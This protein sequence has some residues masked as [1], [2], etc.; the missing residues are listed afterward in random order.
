MTALTPVDVATAEQLPPAPLMEVTMALIPGLGL[1]IRTD[2]HEGD[3][4]LLEV[5]TGPARLIVSFDVGHAQYLGAEH[6]A[7]AAQLADAARALHDEVQKLVRC[8]E[9][10]GS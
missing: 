10:S 6:V 2:P 7:L 4:P 8:R 5:I 3:V 1:E 9:G